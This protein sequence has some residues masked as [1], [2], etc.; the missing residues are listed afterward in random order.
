MPGPEAPAA[1]YTAVLGGY[2]QL[3]EEPLAKGSDIRFVCFTDDP[4]L[5]SETWEVVTIEPR[6]PT[7]ATRSARHVKICGHPVLDEFA[8]TLW[9]DN[10]VE[11]ATEPAQILDDWLADADIAAPLHSFHSTVLA[12][13]EAIIDLGKDDYVRVYEQLSHYLRFAAAE[14]EQNPHWTAILARRRTPEVRAAMQTWWEHV[15][16]FSRRDQLSFS[17]VMAAAE[18][19]LRSV[20]LSNLSSALHTWPRAEGRREEAVESLRD[21]LRPPAAALG[22]AELERTR[23]THEI[24]AR[25]LQLSTLGQERDRLADQA[26]ADQHRANLLAAEVAHLEQRL[27]AAETGLADAIGQLEVL[28]RQLTGTRARLNRQRGRRKTLEEMLQDRGSLS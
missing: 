4:A 27:A 5:T 7:D 28:R 11:L 9:I 16:R 12:E 8:R 6:F 24:E 10:S 20:P 14:L 23:L 25:D 15:L 22:A 1:V 21:A 13:A 26:T 17:V 18:V 2:E 3:R 19:R